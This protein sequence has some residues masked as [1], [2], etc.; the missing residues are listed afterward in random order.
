[1]KMGMGL[2]G[3]EP[4]SNEAQEVC[5]R[6]AAQVRVGDMR[7]AG[8]EGRARGVAAQGVGG[9]KQGARWPQRP[10]ALV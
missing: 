6:E 3:I 4:E 1:M 2:D 8:T 5:A 9:C 10:S 7:G